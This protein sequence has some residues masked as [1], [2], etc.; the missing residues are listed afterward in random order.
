MAGP[1]RE[2]LER[3]HEGVEVHK[4]W[5][6]SAGARAPKGCARC[7]PVAMSSPRMPGRPSTVMLASG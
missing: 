3:L 1:A 2:L 4:A 5:V 6:R 7:S